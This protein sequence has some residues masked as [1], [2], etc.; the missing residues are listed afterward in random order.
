MVLMDRDCKE[1]SIG[2]HFVRFDYFGLLC[3]I[4]VAA[5]DFQAAGHFLTPFLTE[6]VRKKSSNWDDYMPN[7]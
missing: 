4:W 3:E 6:S 7:R 2:G 5:V 1:L